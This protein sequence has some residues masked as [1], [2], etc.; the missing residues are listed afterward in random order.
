MPWE[1][2]RPAAIH[3][4]T[5]R[6]NTWRNMSLSHNSLRARENAEWSGFLSSILKPQNPRC[7][8]RD[9][10]APTA[11]LCRSGDRDDAWKIGPLTRQPHA[12]LP[13]VLEHEI[14]LG[15]AE[16]VL[17]GIVLARVGSFRSARMA[18]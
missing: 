8:I 9:N 4:S 5:P 17:V 18:A 2:H 11:C 6:S 10:G 12:A 14:H 13:H 16:G 7:A 15:R 3:S 1:T